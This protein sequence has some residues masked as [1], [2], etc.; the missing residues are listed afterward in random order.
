MD[1]PSRQGPASTPQADVT[2]L[3]TR[4]GGGSGPARPHFRAAENVGGPR[5]AGPG[6]Q[7]AAQEQEL[8]RLEAELES[9]RR[10][11]ERFRRELDAVKNRS[12]R[13]RTDN[14]A[15]DSPGPVGTGQATAPA[16]TTPRGQ[17]RTTA[18]ARANYHQASLG[19]IVF[20]YQDAG[21]DGTVLAY[22]RPTRRLMWRLN[23]PLNAD[24][25]ISAMT[26][27]PCSSRAP[28][29]TRDS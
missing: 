22:D 24:S 9:A 3:D 4:Y 8:A 1:R 21:S 15:P 7:P 27:K 17:G 20:A 11:V 28:T 26:T 25:V 10:N 23:A 13:P 6:S 5:I 18:S 2:H 16:I 19:H 12:S 29:A 14:S